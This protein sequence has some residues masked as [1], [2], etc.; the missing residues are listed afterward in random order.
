METTTTTTDKELFIKMAVS[1]W[2]LQ[3]SRLTG[4]LNKLTDEELA[5]PTAP[6]RNTGAY[7]LGHLIAVSDGLFT[8]LQLGERLHPEL[9]ELYLRNPE[10][11]AHDRPSLS[12]LKNYLVEVNE[13]LD[14]KIN[15]IQPDEWF[16]AHSAISAEDFAKEPFRNKLNILMNRTSHMAYHIGQ[17]IYLVKPKS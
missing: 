11:S 17:L 4:L 5:T 3:N 14:Q 2:E 8:F 16:T 7:I 6:G 12:T 9:E 15:A 10:K 1:N 13:L